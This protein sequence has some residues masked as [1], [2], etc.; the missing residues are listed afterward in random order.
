MRPQTYPPVQLLA[1]YYIF[2]A[3]LGSPLKQL[4]RIM[5]SFCGQ[6]VSSIKKNVVAYELQ[7]CSLLCRL[8]GRIGIR[9]R[10]RLKGSEE[11][12]LCQELGGLCQSHSYIIAGCGV[13][14]REW[15]TGPRG[16]L[17][18]VGSALHYLADDTTGGLHWLVRGRMKKTT[19]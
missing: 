2:E 10:R 7:T 3:F 13:S 4:C 17:N 8:F 15:C 12:K 6:S 5:S 18:S 19:K 16:K 1:L 9:T 14:P 11:R